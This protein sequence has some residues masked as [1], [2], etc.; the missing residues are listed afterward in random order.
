MDMT[1]RN[2]TDRIQSGDAATGPVPAAPAPAAGPTLLEQM[3]GPMGFVY[4][5]VPVLV[6]VTANAFLPLAVTIGV[7]LGAGIGLT[8]FRTV[9][10]EAFSSAIGSTLGVALAVGI[11]AFTG[12]A[13]DFFVVGIWAAL[14]AFV[15]SVGSV[16]ARRPLSGVVWN[17]LH[18]GTHDWRSD[19]RVVRAH[20]LATLAFATVFAAR[21]VVQQWLYLADS[22]AGLGVARIVMGVP[23]TVVAALAVVW[24]FRRST[25]RLV[26]TPGRGTAPGP[27]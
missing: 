5:V 6:F 26:G 10:G 19:R 18:G 17:A 25:T 21:F 16:L 11:V 7:A 20:D 14:A 27:A 4:S 23:L 9:R 15:V 24:A 12:S 8:V 3:G 13:R 22:T 1:D 2:P